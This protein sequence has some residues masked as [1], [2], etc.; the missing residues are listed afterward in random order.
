MRVGLNH[1]RETLLN[2]GLDKEKVERQ[3]YPSMLLGTI[4]LTPFEVTQMYT[5]LATEGQYKDLTDFHTTVRQQ[6]QRYVGHVTRNIAGRFENSLPTQNPYGYVPKARQKEAIDW[7]GRNIFDTP[8]WLYPESVVTK[9]GVDYIDEIRSRQQTVIAML[10]SPGAIMNLH[11]AR[12][13]W[14]ESIPGKKTT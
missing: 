3:I 4:E 1:V 11:N 13:Q 8:M 9:L 5:S 6:Y 2:I 12:M 10:L 14:P 7:V